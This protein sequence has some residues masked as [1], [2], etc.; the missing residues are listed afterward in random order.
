MRKTVRFVTRCLL[1]LSV[2]LLPALAGAGQTGK[3]AG[4]VTDATNH[5]PLVGATVILRETTIGTTTDVD[6]YY[7]INNIPPGVVVVSVSF[8]GYRR[9]TVSN[10]QVKIDLTTR[11]D[12]AMQQEAVLTDEVVIVAERPLVQKDLT[13]SSVTVS[14]EDLRRIP[15]E[16]ISQVVNIQAGVVGGHFRGGRSDEV[17]YLVDGVAVNDPYNGAMAMQVDNTSIREMEVIS[18]TFNAEYG[19]AM[20]GIV[21]IVTPD[22]S[23]QYHGSVSLYT[24]GLRHLPH[25]PLSE[26][27]RAVTDAHPERPGKCERIYPRSEEPD[28]LCLGEAVL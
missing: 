16:N 1:I 3:I 23:S 17:A 7:S 24:G 4:R 28:V 26:C 5:E 18:G 19:Q 20:S 27:R 14:N 15:T 11:V 22:G 8:I 25:R 9:T 2:G 21:N 10:V 12:V 13:S 6:G